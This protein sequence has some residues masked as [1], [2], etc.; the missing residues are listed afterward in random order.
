MDK[1]A[2]PRSGQSAT[3]VTLVPAISPIFQ[4]CFS[5]SFNPSFTH[6]LCQIV[7]CL[8]TTFQHVCSRTDFLMTCLLSPSPSNLS[9]LLSGRV[10][11]YPPQTVYPVGELGLPN[12]C[13]RF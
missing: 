6:A 4:T 12:V 11:V 9:R 2:L 8:C 5:W 13:W 1:R 3:P 7:H 10:S